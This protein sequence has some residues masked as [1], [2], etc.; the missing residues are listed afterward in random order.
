MVS[1]R[2]DAVQD[3]AILFKD[4]DIMPVGEVE[5]F[6]HPG[7]CFAL[8]GPYLEYAAPVIDDSFFYAMDSG[9][10]LNFIFCCH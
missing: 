5:Q 8:G 2:E 3:R 6:L 9:D 7:G 1:P 10:Q 4:R